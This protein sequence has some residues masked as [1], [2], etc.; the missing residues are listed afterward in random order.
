MLSKRPRR[1]E[2][3]KP[4]KIKKIESERTEDLSEE[5]QVEQSFGRKWTLSVAIPGSVVKTAITPELQTVLVGQIAR[6]LAIFQVDEVI[7]F[8]DPKQ[9]DKALEKENTFNPSHFLAR[10]L[11]YQE[12]PP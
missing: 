7:V 4:K 11:Q 5:E 1:E 9:T 8:E 12:C 6:C 2:A 10:L 3:H